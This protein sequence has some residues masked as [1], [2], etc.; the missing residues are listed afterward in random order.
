M[1][2][3]PNGACDELRI[4]GDGNL[5]LVKRVGKIVLDGTEGWSLYSSYYY[6]YR[7]AGLVENLA[8]TVSSSTSK[9]ALS[10]KY[11]FGSPSITTDHLLRMYSSDGTVDLQ[12]KSYTTLAAF[13]A[14]LAED[15]VTI[16]YLL[17]EEEVI[18]LGSI[19]LPDLPTPEFYLWTT[20]NLTDSD[21]DLM[22]TLV[23]GDPREDIASFSVFRVT[24]EGRVCLASNLAPGGGLVDK[25]APSNVEFAYELVA[26]AES[27]A[28]SR[29]E[30]ECTVVT[31]WFFLYFEDDMARARWDPEGA[32]SLARPS[33]QR[34]WYAGRR[35]PVSYDS[36]HVSDERTLGAL[37]MEPSEAAAFR[38]L[39]F[40]GGRAVYKSG[41]GDVMHV[42]VEVSLAPAYASQ[43]YYGT[44][45]VGLVRIDGEAL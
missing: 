22:Q 43:A 27:G 30:C 17:A 35:H 26:Y 20:S 5:T 14:A 32:I 7:C 31:P 23:Y 28:Y 2:A 44:V 18:D 9:V 41:D 21:V 33:K 6:M 3:L 10:S 45:T 13:K 1:A 34:V 12:D 36:I 16:Y 24:D 11:S 15:P 40:S 29:I 25:Y 38:R 8:Q 37:L 4:D 19:N 39:V 42:D